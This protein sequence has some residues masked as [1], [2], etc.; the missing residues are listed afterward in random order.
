MHE[1]DRIKAVMA[2]GEHTDGDLASAVEG[3]E[4]ARQQLSIAWMV[5]S[6][7]Q[8]EERWGSWHRAWLKRLR[9]ALSPQSRGEPK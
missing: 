4:A 7:I 9:E 5:Y 1:L 3:W 8:D 6:E 2:T